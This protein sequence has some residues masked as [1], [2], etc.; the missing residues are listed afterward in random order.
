M[1]KQKWQVG[2]EVEVQFKGVIASVEAD[3]KG[4]IMYKVEGYKIEGVVSPV[5][6]CARESDIVPLP[7]PRG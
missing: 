6:I 2:D 3:H 4:R 7:L 1:E 5:V